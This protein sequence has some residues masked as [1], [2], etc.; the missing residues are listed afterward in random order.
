[1]GVVRRSLSVS[2]T[3]LLRRVMK[4]AQS[5]ERG[6]VEGGTRKQIIEGYLLVA[7][8]SGEAMSAVV[9]DLPAWLVVVGRYITGGSFNYTRDYVQTLPSGRDSYLPGIIDG[10]QAPQT[11]PELTAGEF[12][13]ISLGLSVGPNQ[14]VPTRYWGL[15]QPFNGVGAIH[16]ASTISST[17]ARW[18]M[19]YA[20]ENGQFAWRLLVI[21]P[22]NVRFEN[23]AVVPANPAALQASWTLSIGESVLNSVGARAITRLIDAPVENFE[24]NWD[25]SQYPWITHGK[26]Q[27]FVSD[28]GVPGY[29]ITVAAQVVYESGGP[30][31]WYGTEERTD[32]GFPVWSEISKGYNAEGGTPSGARGLWA[33]DIEVVGTAATVIDAYKVFSGDADRTP[34]LRDRTRLGGVV[35]TWYLNNITYRSPMTT[36]QA[37]EDRRVSVMLSSTFV[38]R[39]PDDFDSQD[40]TA[41][42]FVGKLFVD[43]TWFENGSVRRQNLRT[44]EL[45]RGVFHPGRLA[46]PYYGKNSTWDIG[47][48]NEGR[49]TIGCDT[50]GKQ[51]VFPVFSSFEPGTMP[52]LT[53][54][55]ADADGVRTAYSGTP[56]FA[57]CLACGTGEQANFNY[58]TVDSPDEGTRTL[59]EWITIPAGFDQVTY[60]GNGRYA[61]YV[62]SEIS[63]RPSDNY[64]WAPDGNIAVATF[65]TVTNDVRVEGVIESTLSNTGFGGPNPM[66]ESEAYNYVSE[67]GIYTVP[68]VSSPPKLGR[69]EV[70]R[71][72]S[73]GYDPLEPAAGGHPATLIA[74]KGYGAPGLSF[75]EFDTQDI[76]TGI[77]WISYD[78]GATWSQML[79]YG[80]PTGTFHCGNIAQARSEPVVRI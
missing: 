80:S 27:S 44:T 40:G 36:V 9:I 16:S 6:G 74:S 38:D 5:M 47:D 7:K 57:M 20:G 25:A 64:F 41:Q 28:E 39:T 70:V 31:Y 43:I 34:V 8:K 75:A 33:A 56:G 73:E 55:V 12:G 54:Y 1:M 18:P 69:I 32:Q 13:S 63:S 71:P 4:L 59:G 78:S 65:S 48:A 49:F 22:F 3:W 46:A 60:I 53:V 52:N 50:D 58:G 26:P 51:V 35:G 17:T 45:K 30:Y 19:T 79:E 76:K 10:I 37:D 11:S 15:A 66:N 61:F 62:S 23:G 42:E 29:R 67:N 24:M 21:T 2:G 68:T 14:L 72:E 77:T